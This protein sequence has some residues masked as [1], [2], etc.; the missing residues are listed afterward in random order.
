MAHQKGDRLLVSGSNLLHGV[1]VVGENLI[2]PA[3]EGR[4]VRDLLTTRG[5][6]LLRVLSLLRE[7]KHQHVRLTPAPG[8]Q[9]FGPAQAGQFKRKEK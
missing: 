5:D 7:E 3:L 6:E 9:Y 8:L 2:D 4:L 1:R